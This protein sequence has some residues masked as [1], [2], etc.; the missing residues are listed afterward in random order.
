MKNTLISISTTVSAGLCKLPSTAR[1]TQANKVAVMETYGV[2]QLGNR[3][4]R[5]VDGRCCLI[6]PKVKQLLMV[7]VNSVPFAAPI[8]AIR[9]KSESG[10]FMP[11]ATNPVSD[12][13][14]F[15]SCSS[16]GPEHGAGNHDDFQT[17]DFN[18]RHDHVAFHGFAD[19]ACIQASYLP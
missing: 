19:D 8:S 2:Q 17:T 15:A 1:T 18:H 4:V 7:M 10:K 9:P 5:N 12:P 6:L 13:M 14:E 3:R 11:L 16:A